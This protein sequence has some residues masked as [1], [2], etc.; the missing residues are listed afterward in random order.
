M[1]FLPLPFLSLMFVIPFSGLQSFRQMSLNWR[2]ADYK[3]RKC[4]M[5]VE[6]GLK[7]IGM[8]LMPRHIADE[9]SQLS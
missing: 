5:V 1:R 3:A 2:M 9:H 4:I 8:D 7:V 6:I